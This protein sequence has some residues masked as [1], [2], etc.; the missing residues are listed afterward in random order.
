MFYATTSS[1]EAVDVSESMATSAAEAKKKR[2]RKSNFTENS[3]CIPSRAAELVE[4]RIV[5]VKSWFDNFRNSK[6]DKTLLAAGNTRA[7]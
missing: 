5:R 1:D 7:E 2:G 4:Q 6:E 3:R